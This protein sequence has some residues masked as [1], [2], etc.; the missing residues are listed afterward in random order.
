MFPGEPTSYSH[1]VGGML[2]GANF[3]FDVVN[4]QMNTSTFHMK[5]NYQIVGI[6]L[7]K[8]LSGLSS[9]HVFGIA[10]R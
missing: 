9:T 4:Y 7:K 1:I 3:R 10:Q 8:V 2:D 5:K 6:Y